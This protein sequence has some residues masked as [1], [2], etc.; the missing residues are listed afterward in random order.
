MRGPEAPTIVMDLRL[1]ETLFD[2]YRRFVSDLLRLT[3]PL[4]TKLEKGQ[5]TTLI[6]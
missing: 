1:F 4:N 3:E 5:Q 2:V 6:I